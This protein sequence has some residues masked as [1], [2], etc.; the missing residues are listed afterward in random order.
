VSNVRSDFVSVTNPLHPS[1][2]PVRLVSAVGAKWKSHGA[3]SFDYQQGDSPVAR[4]LADDE[5]EFSPAKNFAVLLALPFQR[6]ES[7]HY[8]K[9]VDRKSERIGVKRRRHV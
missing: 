3:D 9:S 4:N 8:Q 7:S 2:S 1:S 5:G 6:C